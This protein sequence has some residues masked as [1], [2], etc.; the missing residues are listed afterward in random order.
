MDLK[1]GFIRNKG[2]I[3]SYSGFRII[4]VFITQDVREEEPMKLII[5]NNFTVHIKAR[6]TH[7]K[8]F[9]IYF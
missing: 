1:I 4:D 9:V 8:R 3:L 5:I 6:S 2:K 7:E